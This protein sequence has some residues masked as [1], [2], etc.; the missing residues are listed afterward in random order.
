MR[1]S[2]SYED[3]MLKISNEDKDILNDIINENLQTTTK[4]N[5]PFF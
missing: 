5:L 4:T 1:G 2:F 3:V